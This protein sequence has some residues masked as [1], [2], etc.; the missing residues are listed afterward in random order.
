[1][2]A[3]AA[4]TRFFS[5]L[6]PTAPATPA[7]ETS[8]PTAGTAG[9]AGPSSLQRT[10]VVL[11]GVLPEAGG[12]GGT[13]TGTS[14]GLGHGTGLPLNHTQPPAAGRSTE[15]PAKR[16]RGVGGVGGVSALGPKKPQPRPAQAA[17]LAPSTQPAR[18]KPPT[19]Y[20]SML[21]QL[22]GPP[23]QHVAAGGGQDAGVHPVA[24]SQSLGGQGPQNQQGM[25]V[26]PSGRV[27]GHVPAAG[28][29]QLP[30]GSTA[31]TGHHTVPSSSAPGV[32]LVAG[33]PEATVQRLH[34]CLAQSVGHTDR[35]GTGG[36]MGGGT[37][38][39][40]APASVRG[41]G[42]GRGTKEGEDDDEE[43]G[44]G[45]G[46]HGEQGML[47]VARCEDCGPAMAHVVDMQD[48]QQPQ[49]HL[50]HLPPQQPHDAVAA[51]AGNE[52]DLLLQGVDLEEQRRIL[53]DLEIQRLQRLGRGAKHGEGGGKAGAAVKGG[54]AVGTASTGRGGRAAAGAGGGVGRGAG[55]SKKG[56]PGATGAGAGG[57]QMRLDALLRK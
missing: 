4:I 16:R 21:H 41:E 14:G 11:P 32:E 47:G 50:Q 3:G 37:R 43:E 6:T 46:A 36:S 55:A 20:Q 42:Y 33:M 51:V 38:G 27:P 45:V 18:T 54:P 35:A 15:P 5:S 34:V 9:N 10:A 2:D 30:V 13:S 19:A 26:Q 12:T 1:M 40:D 17:A 22:L 31:G 39:G 44:C 25:G 29:G 57:K 52:D 8:A 23:A 56:M 24:G 28:D 7:T 53:H 49:E 48:Q